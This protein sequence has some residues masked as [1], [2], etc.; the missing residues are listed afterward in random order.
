MAQ[1]ERQSADLSPDT[2]ESTPPGLD[3]RRHPI[4]ALHYFGIEPP[5]PW[6]HISMP[7]SRV[8]GRLRVVDGDDA[9]SEAA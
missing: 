9:E 3:A 4:I 2:N 7:L 6:K 1:L 5:R 8:I